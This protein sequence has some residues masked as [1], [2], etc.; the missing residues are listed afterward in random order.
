M[1]SVVIGGDTFQIYGTSAGAD[2]YW[3]AELSAVWSTATPDQKA[4]ALVNATRLLDRMNWKGAPVGVPQIDVVLQWPRTGVTDRDGAA[5]S[6]AAV[7]DQVIKATYELAR[8]LR[9]NPALM[10]D[11]TSGKNIKRV[12]AGPTEVEFFNP[13]LGISGRFPQNIT[14]LIGQFLDGSSGG[15][16]SGSASY[17][18][19]GTTTSAFDDSAGYPLTGPN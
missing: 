4:S 8:M 12:Q 6:S 2:S 19:D 17:G 18:T 1:G 7:P 13:T 16:V 11:V 5:V 3:R 14:E 15:A 9:T 10:T